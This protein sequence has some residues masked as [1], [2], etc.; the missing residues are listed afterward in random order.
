M[1]GHRALRLRYFPNDLSYQCLVGIERL[2]ITEPSFWA[3]VGLGRPFSRPRLTYL[4]ATNKPF[5]A[6]MIVSLGLR[7]SA[8]VDSSSERAAR[9]AFGHS[10]AT[11]APIKKM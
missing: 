10:E 8:S 6:P 3:Q 2:S 9:I 5:S 4:S 1:P 7:P 11:S